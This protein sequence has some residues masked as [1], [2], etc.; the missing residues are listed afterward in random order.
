MNERAYDNILL[1]DIVK[2]DESLTL[3]DMVSIATS[4]VIITPLEDEW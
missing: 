2:N 1:Y 4:R 3:E